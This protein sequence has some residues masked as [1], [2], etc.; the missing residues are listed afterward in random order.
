MRIIFRYLI[1]LIILCV[2]LVGNA[3]AEASSDEGSLK[4][5]ANDVV[6]TTKVK[7]Q[8][9]ASPL[10][11]A[12]LIT[13]ETN[14][15]IVKLMGIL[16]SQT[17][18]VSAIQIAQSTVGVKDVDTSALY[19]K[20]D[21]RPSSKPVQDTYI[22]AKVKGA[23]I[24]ERVIN[25]SDLPAVGIKVETISSVVYLTG[26]VKSEDQRKKIE[27]IAKSISGVVRVAANLEIDDKQ[28]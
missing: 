25:D 10:T 17:E 26:K 12:G 8:L 2:A 3:F 22:T 1:F 9:A 16:D 28:K 23:L 27:E 20:G 5:T 11:K 6:I 14:S 15:G 21:T 24:R 7:T 18:A 13:V 19:V 4:S